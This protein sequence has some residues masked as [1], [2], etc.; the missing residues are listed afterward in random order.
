LLKRK[1]IL[2]FR[3]W[4]L[5]RL[6]TILVYKYLVNWLELLY[7]VCT[8]LGLLWLHS[9]RVIWGRAPFALGLLFVVLA[10]WLLEQQNNSLWL[11][12]GLYFVVQAML[13]LDYLLER[14]S[15]WRLTVLMTVLLGT[16]LAFFDGMGFNTSGV[17]MQAGL[18]GWH[19]V[20]L[21]GT[22]VTIWSVDLLL[23]NLGLSRIMSLLAILAFSTW[24]WCSLLQ[25][26][27]SLESQLLLVLV[28]FVIL[29]L[30]LE[31][32]APRQTMPAAQLAAY[33]NLLGTLEQLANPTGTRQA[34][35]DLVTTLFGAARV[36]ASGSSDNELWSRVLNTAVLLVPG[37]EGGSVR[38]RVGNQF[39]YVAQQ[40]YSDDLFGVQLSEQNARDWHGDVLAWHRGEPRIVRQPKTFLGELDPSHILQ[41]KQ[42][43]ANL[44][45][46]VVV[47][48]EVLA[49]LNLDNFGNE[50]AFGEASVE[51]ARQ[52][53]LQVGALIS[54]QRERREL[55]TRLRE[56]AAIEA[57]AQALHDARNPVQIANSILEQAVQLLDIS[58]C[59]FLLIS[60]DAQQ[61]QVIANRG[62]CHE[63]S[64]VNDKM[65]V[66]RGVGLSWVALE[67]RGT[68]YSGNIRTDPR[69]YKPILDDHASHSHSQLTIPI[70]DSSGAPLGVLLIA[71][72]LPAEFTN[73]DQ[74]LAELIAKVASSALERIRA[75]ENLERQIF[76]SRNLLNLARLL[77]SSDQNALENALERIRQLALA[78]AALLLRFESGLFRVQTQVG[79][80]PNTHSLEQSL[81]L[82]PLLVW[83]RQPMQRS[84][85]LSAEV[86][87]ASMRQISVRS[88]LASMLDNGGTLLGA[89]VVYRFDQTGWSRNEKH[90]IEAAGG[91][92]GA[93]LARL[94]R[95]ETLEAAYEGSLAMIGRALEMR[96]LE[97]GN[98]TERVTQ[99][100]V[101]MAKALNLPEPEIRAVRWG[102][103][104]HD[105]GKF[106][107]SDTIL[108]KPGKLEPAE[109]ELIRQHPQNGYDLIRDIPFLPLTTKHIVL[110]HHERWDGTG[111]PTRLAGED[112]PLAARIFAVCDVFDALQSKRV[113][114]EAFS[115]T[116]TLAELYSSAHDGHLEM[117]LVRLLE[118][119]V[120]EGAA[121]A[122]QNAP[123]EWSDVQSSRA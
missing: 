53:A 38:L 100:A 14:T 101:R 42:L 113:Y 80:I 8:L 103:Y 85:E 54:A 107:I 72:E 99:M 3:S 20:F 12:D 61:L 92:I 4:F 29:A 79:S 121:L 123:S 116:R 122:S 9:R 109:L 120:Q 59:A 11:S 75:T 93:L 58:N 78:D 105:V 84:L 106:A 27:Y 5:T 46:P 74:R 76:E 88:M 66:P 23:K 73:F 97:T 24:M 64:R 26:G 7:A 69:A 25:R 115:P 21:L 48:N 37:A 52:F 83:A 114:K 41:K 47:G 40:G 96:D 70:L 112:I 39:H 62:T 30:Y 91:M 77:E 98:H 57:V 43:R 28:T 90:L 95:V 35:K 2:Y 10:V 16:L 65:I 81:H 56:F 34:G 32:I 31:R 86:V 55:E 118:G 19:S 6:E 18:I 108:R 45:M 102:A 63:I 110:Y 67:T 50:N 44:Y 17:M 49:D 33:Q 15:S 104:L 22:A 111:Y 87:G 51:A 82:E 13:V 117:R 119:L 68:I 36:M 94:E 71:R 89:I 60:A 1:H